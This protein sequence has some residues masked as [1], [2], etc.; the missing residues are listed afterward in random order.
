MES[1]FSWKMAL[2]IVHASDAERHII[3]ISF[4]RCYNYLFFFFETK[5]YNYFIKIDLIGLNTFLYENQK[6]AVLNLKI[7]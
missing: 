1:G 2:S 4:T 6:N 7:Y 3:I 5:C